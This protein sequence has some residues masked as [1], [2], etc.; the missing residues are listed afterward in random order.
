ME[1]LLGLLRDPAQLAEHFPAYDLYDVMTVAGPMID[2]SYPHSHGV[3]R[4]YAVKPKPKVGE[5]VEREIVNSASKY[6][7]Q[8]SIRLLEA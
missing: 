3:D 1:R 2:D 5:V 6:I 4:E 8:R 7:L